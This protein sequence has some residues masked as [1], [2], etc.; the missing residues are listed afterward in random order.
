MHPVLIDYA[1]GMLA[2][3]RSEIRG[4]DT[5]LQFEGNIPVQ[6]TEPA[7]LLLLGTVDLNILRACRARPAQQRST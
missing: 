4:T 3:Q 2:I 1:H 5:D 7:S 6:S